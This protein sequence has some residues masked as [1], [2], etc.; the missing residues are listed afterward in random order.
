MVFW[1]SVPICVALIAASSFT[2]S[3]GVWLSWMIGV[4]LLVV[5]VCSGEIAWMMRIGSDA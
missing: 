3:T 1:V 4:S 2:E 5:M